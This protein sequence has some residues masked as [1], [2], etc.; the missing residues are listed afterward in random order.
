MKPTLADLETMAYGAGKILRDSYG[1]KIKISNKGVIDLITEIDQ[2]SEDYLVNAIKSR[3]PNHRVIT[4]ESGIILGDENQ[5]WYIDPLDGTVNYAHGVPIFSVS[6]AY[7]DNGKVELGGIYDPMHK[8]YFYASRGGGAWLNG[9]KLVVS[10]A[11]N[12]DQSLLVTGFPY[13]VRTNPNNNMDHY[14][15][16][17]L[18]SR[19]VRRLGSA[20]I[21]MAYVAAGRFDGFWEISI[22]G[23]DIAAGSLIV[24]EAGGKV[25]DVYGKPEYL[26]PVTSI[27]AT[28][29]KIHDEMLVVL[30]G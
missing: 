6:I 7:V 10:N 12:L 20:A 13:D 19:G 22:F 11:K 3:F 4:E 23:W 16:L 27:L 8:E 21:D 5:A 18:K 15:N 29:S 1:K 30:W 17:G 26:Y 25:T 14:V 24:K 28:N 2:R 9:H